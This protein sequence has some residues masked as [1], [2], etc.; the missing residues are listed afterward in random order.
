MMKKWMIAVCLMLYVLCGKADAQ[1]NLEQY[2]EELDIMSIQQSVD[3]M[4]PEEKLDIREL[5]VQLCK[6]ELQPAGK[7]MKSIAENTLLSEIKKQRTNIA[8]ILIL[9][10]AASVFSSFFGVFTNSNVQEIAFYMI[11]LLLFVLLLKSFREMAELS[12]KTMEDILQF[13]KLL[14]PVYLLAA[15]LASR[16]MTAV[17]FYEITLFL[18]TVVQSLIQYIIMPGIYGYLLIAMLN[19]VTREAYLSRM[20]SFLKKGISVMMKSLFGLILGIQTIQ[21]ILFPTLDTLKNSIWIKA[22]SAIPVIGNTLNSVT[23]TLLGTAAVLKNA[24]GAAGMLI[25]IYICIRPVLR[26]LMGMILYKLVSAVIQPVADRRFSEC[27]D[28]MADG[29]ALLLMAVSITGVLFFL[30]IAIVTTAGSGI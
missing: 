4:L 21:R 25:L 29:I 9:A 23:E 26:L 18:I 3:E 8:R 13:M 27:V 11:Y 1:E 7:I 6:G 28:H 24:V 5:L 30:T 17:G 12:G 19:N 14:L 10:I 20:M 16:Q 15:S 2:M 22:G